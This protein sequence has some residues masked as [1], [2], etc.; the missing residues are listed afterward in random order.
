MMVYKISNYNFLYKFCHNKSWSGSRSGLDPYPATGWFRNTGEKKE[1]A[2]QV[3]LGKETSL[4]R[5]DEN[6][7][8]LGG[9]CSGSRQP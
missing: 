1:A 7:A 9:S 3:A 8:I 4:A 6:Y 5:G 2:T